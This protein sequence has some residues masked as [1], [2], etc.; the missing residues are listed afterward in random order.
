MQQQRRQQLGDMTANQCY[1]SNS[2]ILHYSRDIH[3]PADSFWPVRCSMG[4]AM[5]M[6]R[7]VALTSERQSD[8]K[9]AEAFWVVLMTCWPV[10]WAGGTAATFGWLPGH[11]VVTKTYL[12]HTETLDAAWMI[13]TF[14]VEY[15]KWPL[16]NLKHAMDINVSLSCLWRCP[17]F[18]CFLSEHKKYFIINQKKTSKRNFR[19]SR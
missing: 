8:L 11:Y 5:G 2:V 15:W 12:G 3:T 1:L 6:D 18:V 10:W 19:S 7:D 9:L 13:N 4:F 14:R 16:L 17:C